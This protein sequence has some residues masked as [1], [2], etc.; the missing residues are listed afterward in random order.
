MTGVR[1]VV[2]DTERVWVPGAG[3]VMSRRVTRMTSPGETSAVTLRAR[4]VLPLDRTPP[5]PALWFLV[6][7]NSW[8]LHP[9]V[10]TV[11]A[12]AATVTVLSDVIPPVGDTL[13]W[14]AYSTAVAPDAG[15]DSTGAV[16]SDTLWLPAVMV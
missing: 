10:S 2:V 16:T 9:L 6:T 11:P 5:Q 12:G 1:S 8:L 13:N 15:E 14:N 7:L 4:V 3:L